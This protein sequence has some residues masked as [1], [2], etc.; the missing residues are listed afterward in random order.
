VP[1]LSHRRDEGARLSQHAVTM[2]MAVAAL[3]AL[4]VLVA[5]VVQ[6]RA[7][8]DLDGSTVLILGMAWLV[9]LPITIVAL[10]GGLT[11]QPDAF[12]DLVAVYPGWYRGATSIALALAGG[13]AAALL[14]RR[15][16][17]R[18]V[19]IQAAGLLAILL[20]TIAHL[21]SGLHDDALLSRRGDVLLLFLM[22][23]A[24]LQRGRGASVGAGIYGVTLAIASGLLAAS[25]HDIAFVVPCERSCGGLGLAGVL[26]NPDLLGVSLAATIPFAYLG[27]RGGAR[28]LFILY[29][30]GMVLATGSQTAAAAAI[31][32][33]VG[34]LVVRPRLDAD[35][36]TSRRGVV[37][38]LLLALAVFGSVTMIERNWSTTALSGRPVLWQ[39]ASDQIARSPWFGYGP[40]RWARLYDSSNIPLSGERS[41]HNQW[42]DV[43]FAAGWVGAGL[44]IAVAA[45][46]LVSS[47]PARPGVAIALA[48]IAIIGTAEGAWSVGTLDFLSFSFIALILTGATGRSPLAVARPDPVG[49]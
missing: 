12:G 6:A 28:N 20:W 2:I 29:L 27:F 5:A 35:P 42:L 44:F 18:R 22:A 33:V 9:S 47:G 16:A 13:L 17:A 43:L 38:G 40:D 24:V 4:R 8:G 15:L 25:R 26:P 48:T 1:R 21:A 45:A 30:V 36:R 10:T 31:A 49:F 3:V 14:L 23:A 19:P 11:R 34:L 41:A 37:A 32:T 46:M 7:A 39:V